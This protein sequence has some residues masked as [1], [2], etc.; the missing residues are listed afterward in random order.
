MGT[1]KEYKIT[2]VKHYF[3]SYLRY[4]YLWLKKRVY[5]LIFISDSRIEVFVKGVYIKVSSVLQCEKYPTNICTNSAV[6][7]L[8]HGP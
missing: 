1:M 8:Q 3:A 7:G 4:F 5:I 2:H 6:R